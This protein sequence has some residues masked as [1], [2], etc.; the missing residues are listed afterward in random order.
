MRN[1]EEW[2]CALLELMKTVFGI[3]IVSCIVESNERLPLQL[4]KRDFSEILLAS[5]FKRENKADF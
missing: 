5:V 2:I 1:G 3:Q 4:E